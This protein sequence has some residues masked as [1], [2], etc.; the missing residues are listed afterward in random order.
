MQEK[1]I[2]WIK[3]IVH[4]VRDE[5]REYEENNHILAWSAEDEWSYRLW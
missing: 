1:Q 4:K 3:S 5:Q 2:K